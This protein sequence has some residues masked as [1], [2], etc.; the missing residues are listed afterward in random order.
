MEKNEESRLDPPDTWLVQMN[1]LLSANDVPHVRRPM[2]A[3]RE[4]SMKTGVSLGLNDPSVRRIFEWFEKNAPE[5]SHN[6]GSMYVGTYYFDACFW[7]ITIWHIFGTVRVDSRDS[8]TTMPD[9]I[10]ARLFISDKMQDFISV[11]AD[12]A[13]YGLGFDEIIS[14]S[15]TDFAMELLRSADQ[16]LRSTV[17]VLHQRHPNPKAMESSRMAT[18]MFLKSF[19]ARHAGLTAEDAQ[20]KL[21]HNLNNALSEVLKVDANSE[22]ANVGPHLG[23]FPAVGDRYKGESRGLK[24]LWRGYQIAQFSGTFV[25]RNFSGRDI[26]KRVG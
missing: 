26:R 23:V 25:V 1:E 21:R 17:T 8:L 13:D 16:Q 24:D 11:W 22:I 18:E 15:E 20:N 14:K 6:I 10:K 4:W 2:D 9:A 7:P 3:W 5:G 19:L 12:C